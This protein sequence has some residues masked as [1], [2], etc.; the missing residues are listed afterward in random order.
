VQDFSF[1]SSLRPECLITMKRAS[2]FLISAAFHGALLAVPVSFRQ[3]AEERV[4]PVVLINVLKEAGPATTGDGAARTLRSTTGLQGGT[5][6]AA[7]ARTLTRRS[8]SGTSGYEEPL[9]VQNVVAEELDRREHELTI[10]DPGPPV[11]SLSTGVSTQ[12][13]DERFKESPVG[14]LEERNHARE[15]HR[16]EGSGTSPGGDAGNGSSKLIFVQARYAYNPKPDYPERARR[17]GWEGTVLLRVLVDLEG[18]SKR[19]ELSG[20]SGFETLDAAAKETVKGWRFY[21]ARYGEER[22]ESWV[23]VPI[24]FKLEEG[25][26]F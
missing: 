3:A 13:N 2:F 25:G 23:K 18:K 11:A 17:E 26:S 5:K 22:I 21:P 12:V 15:Y 1:T 6:S 16:R 14:T 7:L 9:K 19:V 8:D 20:S 10:P 4:I 24:V